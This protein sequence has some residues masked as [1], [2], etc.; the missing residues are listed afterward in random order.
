VFICEILANM[1]RVSNMAPGPLVL[2]LKCS[3][4]NPIID[5]V[6][7]SLLLTIYPL[8]DL[9]FRLLLI[10]NMKFVISS[11]M[12]WH[13][14]LHCSKLLL[15]NVPQHNWVISSLQFPMIKFWF[16]YCW[17]Y[18]WLSIAIAAQAIFQLSGVG[19]HDTAKAYCDTYIAIQDNHYNTICTWCMA[20]N[21]HG[22]LLLK[23]NHKWI[24]KSTHM[25]ISL[26]NFALHLVNRASHDTCRGH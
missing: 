14:T 7:E 18:I 17:R 4:Q 20:I 10:F 23:K 13:K 25:F 16:L 12:I 8:N 2:L 26:L 3:C 21:C 5:V 19:C 1:T 22:I 24:Q 6:C 15:W 11:I 9:K